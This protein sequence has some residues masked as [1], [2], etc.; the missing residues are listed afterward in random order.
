M[1]DGRV[2][3]LRNLS[4]PDLSQPENPERNGEL[5]S[6]GPG[7]AELELT[8]GG[9]SIPAGALVAFQA[10]GMIYL[11]HVESGEIP[12]DRH[13]LRVRVD[14]SLALQDVSSIQKLWSQEPPD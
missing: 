1:S 6:S 12:G 2:V 9:A 13:R 7:W 14:H 8:D 5:V 3:A 11:G 4:Q 10:S